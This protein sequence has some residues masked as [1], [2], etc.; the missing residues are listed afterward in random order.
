VTGEKKYIMFTDDYNNGR[1]NR[2]SFNSFQELIA[3]WDAVYAAQ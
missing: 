3:K 2:D 1:V